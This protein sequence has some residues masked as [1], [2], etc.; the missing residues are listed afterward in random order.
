MPY[1]PPN[2]AIIPYT[3]DIDA[4]VE[5]AN[6]H[7]KPD[8]VDAIRAATVRRWLEYEYYSS[9]D[10]NATEPDVD[11][12]LGGW[13]MLYEVGKGE[14]KSPED[15]LDSE[16]DVL[17]GLLP[18]K[19]QHQQEHYEATGS[20]VS[21]ASDVSDPSTAPR[22]TTT[23]GSAGSSEE[24][25]SIQSVDVQRVEDFNNKT[26]WKQQ[27]D[28]LSTQT[29]HVKGILQ[30]EKQRRAQ[31][32]RRRSLIEPIRII[33]QNAGASTSGRSQCD[34]FPIAENDN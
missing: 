8:L 33:V 21:N 23:G 2:T 15:W 28:E 29:E 31:Q 22:T 30:A 32:E 9:S 17:A 20:P 24:S 19:A 4:Y 1:A 3:T 11:L 7:E 26:F 16:E 5:E 27:T 18:L 6:Q 10:A 25:F 34:K 12:G 14:E 13:Q